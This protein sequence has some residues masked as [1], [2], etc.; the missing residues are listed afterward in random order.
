L[1]AA[2]R[3]TQCP[4]G[5]QLNLPSIREFEISQVHVATST[6]DDEARADRKAAGKTT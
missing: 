4:T 3:V 5:R 6:F 2:R 1:R